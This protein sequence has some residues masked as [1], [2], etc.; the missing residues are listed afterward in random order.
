ML[1]IKL[2]GRCLDHIIVRPEVGNNE[3]TILDEVETL[4]ILQHLLHS[5]LKSEYMNEDDPLVL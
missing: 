4:H 5:G 3:C 2:D 1:R